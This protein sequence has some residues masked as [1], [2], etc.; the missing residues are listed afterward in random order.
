[1]A[2]YYWQWESSQCLFM[3]NERFAYMGRLFVAL[4]LIF[5]GLQIMSGAFKPLRSDPAFI[6]HLQLFDATTVA[7]M[8]GCVVIGCLLTFVIQSSS[9]MLGITIALATTGAISYPTA[10]A[11]VFGENV[12]T[13]ITA[14]LASIGANTNAKRAALSHATFNVLGVFIMLLI[15]NPYIH[16]I[17][18]IV[19]GNPELLLEDGTKPNIAAHI[20]MGHTIFN[21]IATLVA[22]PLLGILARFVCY[23]IPEKDSKAKG[24]KYIG[25]PG[26]INTSVS[27]NMGKLELIELTKK[28]KQILLLS[29]EYLKTSQHKGKLLDEIKQ[30]ETETDEIQKALTS[31]VCQVMEGKIS[32]EQAAEAYFLIRGADELESIADYSQ[33]LANYK[34]RL[35]KNGHSVSKE[36]WDDLYMFMEGSI[37]LF[38]SIAENLEGKADSSIETIKSNA[39]SLNRQADDIKL[40]HLSRMSSGTCKALPALTYSD[41]IVALRRIKNHTV[42]LFEA[43]PSVT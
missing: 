21:C 5:F 37:N 20:A 9:A 24:I 7:S 26:L 8:L 11:L 27:L 40:N 23:V 36:A 43:S 38:D 2:S 3:R 16:F 30:I 31:F 14:L 33:S 22:I 42:N 10:A 41:M 19:P 35:H 13:T 12:G 34:Y 15:F 18:Y 6:S 1:M 25:T 39:A 4:G 28:T 32:E 29:E 17:D